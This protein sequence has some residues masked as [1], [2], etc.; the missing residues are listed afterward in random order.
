MVFESHIRNGLLRGIND[1]F[2]GRVSFLQI[3]GNDGQMAD[4]LYS[5]HSQHPWSGAIVEP[6]PLYFS[7][8]KTLH[9]NNQRI[10]TLNCAISDQGR[11]LELYFVSP[12]AHDKYP[13]WV[14]GLASTDLSH[15]EKHRVAPEDCDSVRVPCITPSTLV[16]EMGNPRRLNILCVDVEGHEIP[17]LRSFPYDVVFPDLIMFEAWH[18]AEKDKRDLAFFYEQ[19]DRRMVIIGEDAFVLGKADVIRLGFLDTIR[20]ALNSL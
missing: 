20:H 11:E 17:I 10:L 3:G 4:P 5:W 12:N 6:V 2:E 1:E 15:L 18:I 14:N 9:E 8:L 19:H 16:G 7:K 13:G